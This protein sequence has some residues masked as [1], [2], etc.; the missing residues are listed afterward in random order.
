[1]KCDRNPD[2]S[3]NHG[4]ICINTEGSNQMS[5]FLIRIPLTKV[6]VSHGASGS[7]HADPVGQVS[8]IGIRSQNRQIL[9]N[10]FKELTA[11]PLATRLS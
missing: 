8:E 4:T 9:T 6:D 7:D 2:H 11:T 1:M 10:C 3:Q 5:L